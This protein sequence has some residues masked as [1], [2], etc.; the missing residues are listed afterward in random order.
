MR[1]FLV[2][3]LVALGM[4]GA[5]GAAAQERGQTLS[6]ASMAEVI[7]IA[8]QHGYTIK[9]VSSAA[10]EDWIR[11][12]VDGAEFFIIGRVCDDDDGKCESLE[13]TARYDTHPNVTLEEI[14]EINGEF[15]AVSLSKIDDQIVLSRYL[16]L[17]YG[18]SEGNIRYNMHFFGLHVDTILTKLESAAES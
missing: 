13:M 3:M 6:K 14:N 12:D 1:R 18:M 9:G 15:S 17:D 5:I 11:V 8:L 4:M 10:D 2:V 16:V 7:Y